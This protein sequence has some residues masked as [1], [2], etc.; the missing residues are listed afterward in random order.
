MLLRPTP[1]DA[2]HSKYAASILPCQP[3]QTLAY[4]QTATP[5]AFQLPV[6]VVAIDRCAIE[7]R[8]DKTLTALSPTA[9]TFSSTSRPLRDFERL[10]TLGI[11]PSEG[12]YLRRSPVYGSPD[13]VP[14]ARSGSSQTSS[15]GEPRPHR[16]SSRSAG[17]WRVSCTLS[18]FVLDTPV[19]LSNDTAASCASLRGTQRERKYNAVVGRAI[20]SRVPPVAHRPC[21][22]CSRLCRSRKARARLHRYRP[23]IVILVRKVR[24]GAP[25]CVAAWGGPMGWIA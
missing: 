23:Q 19:A 4:Y 3:V 9:S 22:I 6:N 14:L 16:R 12:K 24:Q 20:D 25:R 5:L 7:L 18:S 17:P 8:Q 10:E 11:V 1:P 15:R 21:F 13:S 2:L